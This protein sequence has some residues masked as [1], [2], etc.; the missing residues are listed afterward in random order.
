MTERQ[1]VLGGTVDVWRS[2]DRVAVAL[3]SMP[4]RLRSVAMPAL[5][6]VA[7]AVEAGR[8]AQGAA[9][10]ARAEVAELRGRLALAIEE[11]DG[12]RA[13]LE[14]AQD[15]LRDL[16]AIVEDVESVKLRLA[17]QAAELAATRRCLEAAEEA[18][19]ARVGA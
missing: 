13:R 6:H 18:L 1:V 5:S 8:R 19:S 9:S 16:R 10:T 11:A 2:L 14:A 4:E 12:W 3:L 7:D 17:Q 15:E